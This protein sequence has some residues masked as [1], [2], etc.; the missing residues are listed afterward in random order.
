MRRGGA[1]RVVGGRAGARRS[2]H[3]AHT[4]R[5]L[6]QLLLLSDEERRARGA[7]PRAA[8]ELHSYFGLSASAEARVAPIAAAAAAAALVLVGVLT[9]GRERTR[10]AAQRGRLRLHVVEDDLI[11]HQRRSAH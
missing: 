9:E 3:V 7:G 1:E 5:G 10:A 11:L 6:L 4:N 2:R 8:H